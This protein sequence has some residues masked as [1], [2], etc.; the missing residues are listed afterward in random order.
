MPILTNLDLTLLS[1]RSNCRWAYLYAVVLMSTYVYLCNSFA[2]SF[3]LHFNYHILQRNVHCIV[4][5]Y[6]TLS[7]GTINS[8]KK[9]WTVFDSPFFNNYRLTNV[10]NTKRVRQRLREVNLG[11]WGQCLDTF[12]PLFFW[13]LASTKC[14]LMISFPR[15]DSLSNIVL[16]IRRPFMWC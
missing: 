13:K 2:V 16:F 8:I 4:L 9:K 14:K 7:I 15:F 6:V 12:V 10:I 1:P 11:A 3:C 5:N